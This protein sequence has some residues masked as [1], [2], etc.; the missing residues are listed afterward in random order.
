MWAWNTKSPFKWV[1]M[2]GEFNVD[3]QSMAKIKC[4]VFVAS[5]QD[6]MTAPE[7]PE[8]MARAFGKQAHYFLF[9]TELG[10][11]VHCAI[12]A[13]KQLAQETLGWLEEVFDKVSK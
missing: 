13:E 10:S 3:K 7:Q 11:G 2:V 4:P 6:D 1:T 5:G 8:E 9:K 12:G